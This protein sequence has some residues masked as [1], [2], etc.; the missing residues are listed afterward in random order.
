MLSAMFFAAVFFVHFNGQP[1]IMDDLIDSEHAVAIVSI[2]NHRRR[3]AN[4]GLVMGLAL[5]L[6][7]TVRLD[8][9]HKSINACLVAGMTLMYQY[10]YYVLSPKNDWVLR[11]LQTSEEIEMWIRSYKNMQHNYHMGA[12]FGLAGA[13][14][15]GSAI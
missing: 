14:A 7:C 9:H 11:Y 4:E 6:V 15:L 5:A 8:A 12:L 10:F 2:V 1:E 13:A 3:L